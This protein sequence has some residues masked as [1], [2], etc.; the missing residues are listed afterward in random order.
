MAA[1]A[2]FLV[3]LA[4]SCLL[5]SF[6]SPYSP[7]SCAKKR[8]LPLNLRGLP[9][10]RANSRRRVICRSM[11]VVSNNNSNN[12]AA[13]SVAM[14][15]LTRLT[16]SLE[17]S[18][19][20]YETTYELVKT[21]F[22]RGYVRY[23]ENVSKNQRSIEEREDLFCFYEED[24]DDE[25]RSYRQMLLMLDEYLDTHRKVLVLRMNYLILKNNFRLKKGE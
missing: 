10:L 4:S 16:A 8:A 9:V 2:A 24:S 25:S 12:T 14:F 15:E 17:E 7:F 23:A 6:V 1:A 13:I 18:F 19:L 20:Q 3:L 22:P 5:V 21:G 11:V